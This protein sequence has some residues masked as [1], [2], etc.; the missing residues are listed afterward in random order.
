MLPSCAGIYINL[1]LLIF[2]FLCLELANEALLG[3]VS[4]PTSV[5]ESLIKMIQEDKISTWKWGQA[6]GPPWNLASCWCCFRVAGLFNNLIKTT[7][8]S[9]HLANDAVLWNVSGPTSAADNFTFVK[10]KIP[11]KINKQL[12]GDRIP[13]LRVRINNLA[14]GSGRRQGAGS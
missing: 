6:A 2:I 14:G 4:G 3:H 12:T 10:L 5:A 9:V 7:Y 1:K 13:A 11:K 8:I